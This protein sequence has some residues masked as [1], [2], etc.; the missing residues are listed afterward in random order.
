MGTDVAG[1]SRGYVQ[2][3]NQCVIFLITCLLWNTV[4]IQQ[5]RDTPLPHRFFLKYLN[6][7]AARRACNELFN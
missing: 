7:H 1:K 5:F 2:Q 3:H 4:I 6:G